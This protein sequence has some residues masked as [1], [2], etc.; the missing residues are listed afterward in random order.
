[1]HLLLNFVFRMI[2]IQVSTNLYTKGGLRK[3]GIYGTSAG[4]GVVE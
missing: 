1:M 3:A 2:Q 4:T